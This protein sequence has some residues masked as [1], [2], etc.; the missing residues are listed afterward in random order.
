MR[1]LPVKCS[2]CSKVYYRESGRITEAK[3]FNWR[4][5]CSVKCQSEARNKQIKLV[6]S[7]PGC[8]NVFVRQ[9]NDFKRSKCHYCSRRCAAIVNNSKYI[10]RHAVM[11]ICGYC[12][13]NY[14]GDAKKYCS[15]TCQDKAQVI[16]ADLLIGR[17]R[18]FV[19]I[20]KRIPCKREFKYYHAIRAR[21]GTWNNAIKIAGFDPN[22]VLFANRHIAKDGHEC[23]SFTEKIIDDWMSEKGI[24]HKRDVPYPGKNR[25]TCDFVIGNKWIE[26]FGLAGELKRYDL[27]KRRKLNLVR[28]HNI[29][30]I[31]LFPD[32]IFPKN[33]LS[34]ILDV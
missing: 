17:I 16:P 33:K 15:E 6:C 28:K 25:F 10:K 19:Q 24:E 7:R 1:L 3:K 23:D 8:G 4:Q 32:D 11:K 29:N 26:F 9:L 21:F 13:K 14:N 30:L 12:G 5:F 20:N 31:K 34:L 18:N 2:F 22:P 27:L